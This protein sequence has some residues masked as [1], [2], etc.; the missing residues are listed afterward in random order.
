MSVIKETL[1]FCDGKD[2]GFDCPEDGPVFDG[3]SRSETA[4]SQRAGFETTGW[5][6]IKGKDYCPHC[7]AALDRSGAK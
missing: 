1:I 7:V 3:D 5:K 6:H 2:A 4:K